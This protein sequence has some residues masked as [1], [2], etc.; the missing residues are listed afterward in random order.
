[1]FRGAWLHYCA[2]DEQIEAFIS[3]D[4]MP[5][6][7]AKWI[8]GLEETEQFAGTILSDLKSAYWNA[9]NSYTHGGL[10]QI[11]RRMV[12]EYV[13]G[14]YEDGE[15][16]EVLLFTGTMGLLALGQIAVLADRKDIWDEVDERLK[17]PA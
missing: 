3:T 5:E 7:F 16:C 12:G 9:M 2:T 14:N 8:E 11:S 13:E 15:I 4:A 1:M 6:H 10:R 17:A